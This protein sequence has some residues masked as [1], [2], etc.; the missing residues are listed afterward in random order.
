MVGFA[1]AQLSQRLEMGPNQSWFRLYTIRAFYKRLFP[2]LV[3]III[4]Y[5]FDR[6]Y[7]LLGVIFG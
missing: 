3:S 6:P 5:R 7:G 2:F 1:R 4:F